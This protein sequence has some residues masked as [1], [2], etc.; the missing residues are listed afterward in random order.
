MNADLL[1]QHYEQIADAPDAIARLRRFILD[2]AVRGKLVPQDFGDEPAIALSAKIRLE[3]QRRTDLGSLKQAKRLEFGDEHT[4]PFAVPKGWCW[5]PANEVW[6]FENGDRSKNYPSREHFVPSGVPFVNAGHLVGGRVSFDNMNYITEEKYHKLSGGKLRSGD[7][8]YCLRGSLGKHAVYDCESSAAVA[9]S[10]VI[11]RPVLSELVPYLRVYLD[12]D[13]SVSMLRRFDNGTAQPNLSSANLRLFEIP[14]P[15]LAEQHRIVAKIEELMALCGALEAAR[16]ERETK[17]DR[18]AAASLARLNTPDPETFRDDARFALDAMPA[19]AARP[20]QIKQLRQTILS[21][22]VRGKLVPQD[23]TDEPAVELLQRL[24]RDRRH[25]RQFTQLERDAVQTPLP[26]I[27]DKWFWTT[28]DQLSADEDN[29]IT[30]GPFGSQLKTDH[31]VQ[32][33]GFRVIRLQNIGGGVFRGE[34]Q[35]YIEQSRY[36]RLLK[37]HVKEGDLLVAGLVDPSM[38]CCMVPASI[39]PAL[40]KAD[41]YR[42]A[43]QPSLSSKFLLYFLNSPLAQEFATV[44]HHGMTLTR[45]GLGNFRRIPVP[46]PPLAEQHRIVARVDELMALCDQLETSLTNA[47]DTRKK[48][49]DALLAEA[50]S[51]TT[52]EYRVAAE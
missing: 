1:L 18:L 47:D 19:F 4:F 7:Q 39:G 46:L 24:H 42:F 3:R 50:L 21:L 41:C 33:P 52:T 23:P 31:Y 20:D 34:H 14:L 13:V 49:L 5:V 30:D 45:I 26:D 29:A 8:L 11:L 37:H 17:R 22:A 32:A 2:L 16:T 12:S 10:L 38:R 27:P 35:S 51:L 15:P 6:E 40:V 25:K 48:L 44:H 9:S 36:E 28:A 43:I